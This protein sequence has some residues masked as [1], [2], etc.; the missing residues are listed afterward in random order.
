[1]SNIAQADIS[2]YYDLLHLWTRFNSGFRVYS[3]LETHTIH[4]WLNDLDTGEFSP[5]TIHKLMLSRG[6][7]DG[8]PIEALDAGCGYGGT[9]F[10]LHAAV[11][12]RW[13]GITISAR[14]CAVG[15]KIARKTDVANAVT[16]ARRIL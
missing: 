7:G 3:G 12:G 2:R 4:R 11:G 16:F 10:A 13:H 9:M 5:A 8:S 15:R 14:Q 1:M 6:I